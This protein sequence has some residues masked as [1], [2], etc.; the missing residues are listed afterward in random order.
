MYLASIISSIT[1][2]EKHF[3]KFHPFYFSI[4]ENKVAKHTAALFFSIFQI[5]TSHFFANQNTFACLR[6]IATSRPNRT[7]NHSRIAASV[8][9]PLK[10]RTKPLNALFDVLF[11]SRSLDRQIAMPIRF[12]QICNHIAYVFRIN[13]QADRLHPLQ[14][15]M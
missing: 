14:K 8:T 10:L 11:G 13:A 6:S 7:A 9:K 15:G 5:A 12:L 4:Q 3:T 2:H 1:H